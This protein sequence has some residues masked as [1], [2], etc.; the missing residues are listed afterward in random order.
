MKLWNEPKDFMKAK[1]AKNSSFSNEA[2]QAMKLLGFRIA[3]IKFLCNLLN[4][5]SET[6][7]YFHWFF[8]HIVLG[9][10]IVVQWKFFKQ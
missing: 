1:T 6:Y 5:K 2:I 7:K 8:D 9:K 4:K 10:V 3:K